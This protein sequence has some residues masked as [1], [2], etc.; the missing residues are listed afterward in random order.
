MRM[1]DE[2]FEA[3]SLSSGTF[4]ALEWARIVADMVFLVFGAVPIFL[5]TMRSVLV[6]PSSPTLRSAPGVALR[7]LGGTGR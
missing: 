5:V 1:T 4:H 6:S 2:R 3:V 7:T